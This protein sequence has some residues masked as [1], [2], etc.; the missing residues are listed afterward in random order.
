MEQKWKDALN[1]DAAEVAGW[2]TG[3]IKSDKLE[4]E[5]GVGGPAEARGLTNVSGMVAVEA[6]ARGRRCRFFQLLGCTR[7]HAAHSCKL[8]RIRGQKKRL[9]K[10]AG[11][12]SSA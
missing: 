2:E 6:T 11:Y 4:A 5:R 10:T 9:Y 7:K 1:V 3:G 8:L 12:L